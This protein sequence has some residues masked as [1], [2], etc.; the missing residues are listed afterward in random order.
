MISTEIFISSETR[1]LFAQFGHRMELRIIT[2]V[3]GIRW[4]YII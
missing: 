1:H 4:A 3:E 2:K